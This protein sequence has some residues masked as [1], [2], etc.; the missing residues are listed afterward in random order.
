[1]PTFPIRYTEQQARQWIINIE[2][3]TQEEAEELFIAND[4]DPW[5]MV[6]K[7]NATWDWGYRDGE[8]E[9]VDVYEVH[10]EVI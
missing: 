5:R 1:M 2:A 9:A 10:W 4:E 6:S 7:G 8:G 3:D